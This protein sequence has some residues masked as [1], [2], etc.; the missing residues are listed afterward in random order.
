MKRAR[1]AEREAA[2]KEV[3]E[4]E[5]RASQEKRDLEMR[6]SQ[7]QD[8][9]RKVSDNDAVF[10]REGRAAPAARRRVTR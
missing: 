2:R 5:V 10:C 9:A 4:L 7:E 3:R 8:K 6:A 1:N